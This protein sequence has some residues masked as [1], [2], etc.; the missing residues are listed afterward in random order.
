MQISTLDKKITDLY[1]KY[2]LFYRVTEDSVVKPHVNPAVQTA[3][4]AII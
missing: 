2:K 4:S 3:F 1:L